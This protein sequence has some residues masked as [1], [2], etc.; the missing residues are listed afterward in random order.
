MPK[1]KSHRGL[2]KRVKMSKNGKVKR[3]SGYAGHLMSHKSP[4]QRRRLRRGKVMAS[5]DAK[6]IKQRLEV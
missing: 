6:V 2:R 3:H 1:M 4:E 5:V